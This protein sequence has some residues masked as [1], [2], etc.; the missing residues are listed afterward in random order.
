[1]KTELILIV[2]VALAAVSLSVYAQGDEPADKRPFSFL[3][4]ARQS[5]P[6]RHSCEGMFDRTSPDRSPIGARRELV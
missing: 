1:M 4:P 6:I 3:S 5:S 2:I